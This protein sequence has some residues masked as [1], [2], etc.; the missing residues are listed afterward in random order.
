MRRICL[1][2]T[3]TLPPPNRVREFLASNDLQKRE[4]LVETLLSSPEYVDYWTFRFSD[5]FRVALYAAGFTPKKV[6]PYWEWI[7]DSIAENKPYDQIARERISA[8][9]IA[10]PTASYYPGEFQP[11][12]NMAENRSVF[13]GSKTRLCSMSQSPVRNL[14]ARPVLGTGSFLRWLVQH[15]RRA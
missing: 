3:G 13:M 8:Q 12:D 10:G 15:Q 2:I 14:G 1:D 4:K 11:N 7:R 5:L 6:F 9:G